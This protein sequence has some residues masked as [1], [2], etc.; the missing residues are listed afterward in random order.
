M[1][2]KKIIKSLLVVLIAVFLFSLI[3]GTSFATVYDQITMNGSMNAGGKSAAGSVKTIT[4]SVLTA[5]RYAGSGIALIMLTMIFI[6][7]ILSAA[8][9]RAEIKKNLIPFT[10][11][12][13]VLFAASNLVGILQTVADKMFPES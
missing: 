7:Y 5:V 6:K 8:S 10:V 3:S 2:C 9:E 11:G 12:A 13:V 4:S 1:K